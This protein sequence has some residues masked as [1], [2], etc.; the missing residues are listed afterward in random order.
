L[1]R[2]LLAIVED[3]AVILGWAI[4]VASIMLQAMYKPRY[5]IVV[6]SPISLT[7]LDYLSLFGASVLSGMILV[8]A[9][10]VML[11]YIAS[12]F[13]SLLIM[14][15]ALIS[16]SFLGTVKYSSVEG[17]L[18]GGAAALIF[19]YVFPTAIFVCLAG[20]VLGGILGEKLHM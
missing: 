17:L 8:D 20:G 14:F 15:V 5:G 2:K 19:Q 16:P 9:E 13:T 12:L 11:G 1:V 3:L 7:L 18:Y 10:K 6:A 4:T